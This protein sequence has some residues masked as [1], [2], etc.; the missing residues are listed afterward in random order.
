[1]EIADLERRCH[2]EVDKAWTVLMKSGGLCNTLYLWYRSAFDGEGDIL[3]ADENNV[4]EGFGIGMNER[5]ST[6]W[7][8]DVM[9]AKV[10]SA[11]RGLPIINIL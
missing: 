5:I 3:I 9:F 10:R 6:A 11:V 7:T 8:K 4:P 1:M 2:E